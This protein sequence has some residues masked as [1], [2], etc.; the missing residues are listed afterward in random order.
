MVSHSISYQTTEVF[1]E[2][3]MIS[4]PSQFC[5]T[6]L[7]I[8]DPDQSFE[9]IA[10]GAEAR[11]DTLLLVPKTAEAKAT[12]SISTSIPN[13]SLGNSVTQ[14]S[15]TVVE[16]SSTSRPI[17]TSSKQ[18]PTNIGAIVGGAIGGLTV[19]CL[20]ILGII[21]IRRKHSVKGYAMSLPDHTHGGR[22]GFADGP[23]LHAHNAG[24]AQKNYHWDSSHGPVEIDSGPYI[25]M[26][27]VELPGQ[28]LQRSTETS[29]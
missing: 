21:Y 6:V 20:T 17:P 7:L 19:I 13:G 11:T 25:Q 15:A 16:T 26:Q 5:S 8:N 18:G 14:T 10:C 9:Y 27:P 29:R 4:E 28:I 12:P 1:L 24:D 3:T 22:N 2:L 23:T